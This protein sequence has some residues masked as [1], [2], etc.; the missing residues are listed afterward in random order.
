MLLLDALKRGGILP[1]LKAPDKP[2]VLEELLVLPA[3]S[4]ALPV[5]T[6]MTA[7]M[8]RENQGSTG[9]GGGIALPHGRLEILSEALLVFGKSR[10]GIPFEALD[11]K[12]VHLFFLLLTPSQKPELHLEMLG[13][14]SR[15]L[16]T[17]GFQEKL[18]SGKNA[19]DIFEVFSAA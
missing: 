13:R 12:A 8:E 11:S 5:E 4:L 17:P 15:C 9:I 6:L 16:R 3:H 19:Q 10:K 18:R 14:I 1:D 7:V 2:G